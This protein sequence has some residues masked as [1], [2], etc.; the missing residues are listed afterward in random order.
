VGSGPPQTVTYGYDAAGRLETVTHDDGTV[1]TYT[2]DANGNRLGRSVAPGGAAETGTYD[3]QDRLVTYGETTY[4]YTAAGELAAK[5][6]GSDTT[7]YTYDTLGNLRQ[8]VQADG[9]VLEYVIDPENRRIR[10]RVNGTLVQAFVW[11][12]ALRPAAELDGAGN[13]VARFVYGTRANVP[14]YIV[15]D[16]GTAQAATYRLVPDH[17]GSPRLVVNTSDGSV[18]QRMEYD[19]FGR[20]TLDTNPGFQPFGFAGGLYDRDTGLVRFGAR[21]YDAV[22]GRWTAKDPIGFAGGDANLYGYAIN[23]PVNS[24][25][26]FGLFYPGDFIGGV[27]DLVRGRRDMIDAA[28]VGADAYFHCRANCEAS[29][30]GVGGYHAAVAGSA[31]R[32]ILQNEPASERAS[33]EA[34]N[35][36]G[37]CAGR[38]TPGADCHGACANLIPPWGI[39]ERHLPPDADPWLIYHPQP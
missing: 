6:V 25:D 7:T 8:V 30:R 31:L 13:V 15:K 23:D 1:V 5:T 37:Q 22:T 17:L 39:P 32:E 21:D 26:P 11:E 27:G 4:T 16:P 9:T 38:G 24:I 33:D 3:A 29:R 14:E 20:V 10:K 19:Q 28:T 18:V 2:Y 12:H 34:A 36:Q 35:A